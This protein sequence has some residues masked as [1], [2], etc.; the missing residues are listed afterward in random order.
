MTLKKKLHRIL[1]YCVCASLIISCCVF[2]VP[3]S[4]AEASSEF[5]FSAVDSIDAYDAYKKEEFETIDGQIVSRVFAT[6]ENRIPSSTNSYPP[7]HYRY[8]A[9]L[10]NPEDLQRYY[11]LNLDFNRKN[12]TVCYNTLTIYAD[13]G[14][15][16]ELTDINGRVIINTNGIQTAGLVKYYNKS[17]E[18]GHTVYYIELKPMQSGQS[19]C[20]VTFWTDSENTQPHYSFWFGAP[21]TRKATALLGTVT[22]TVSVPYTASAAYSLSSPYG[23]PDRAWVNT[24]TIEKLSSTGDSLISRAKLNVKLPNTTIGLNTWS[25]ASSPQVFDAMPGITGTSDANGT[26]K[27]NLASVSWSGVPSSGTYQYRGRVS[28]EYLYAFG[29]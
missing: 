1:M 2:P 11:F 27:V 7:N 14:V 21:L 29:A 16:F 25:V 18:N 17:T 3:V 5:D 9:Y 22:L 19:Q 20:M 13:P 24:V 15:K 12:T 26:Y 10:R 23:I 4:A 8:G 28:L 6:K